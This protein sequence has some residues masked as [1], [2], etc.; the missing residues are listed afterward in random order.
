M[1]PRRHVAQ[2][3]IGALLFD[4]RIPRHEPSGQFTGQLCRAATENA[5][6]GSPDRTKIDKDA[7]APLA[8][9]S[10]FKNAT[11]PRSGR[12]AASRSSR[13]PGPSGERGVDADEPDRSSNC[14]AIRAAI[15]AVRAANI[16]FSGQA[17]G[18][19]HAERHVDFCIV[20]AAGSARPVLRAG[21]VRFQ[22]EL[23]GRQPVRHRQRHGLGLHQRNPGVVEQ[24]WRP[25]RRRRQRSLHLSAADR[26]W[27]RLRGGRRDAARGP[28]LH[29]RQRFRHG[30]RQ[31]HRRDG[32]LCPVHVHAAAVAGH[33][34]H[35]Q[36]RQ[37]QLVPD[38]RRAPGIRGAERR[39]GAAGPHA[40]EPGRFRPA[41]AVRRRG[42]RDRRRGREDPAGGG[43]EL[44][45]HEVPARAR[46]R[47]RDLLQRPQE[48]L[49]HQLPDHESLEV[50]ERRRDQRRQRDVLLLEVLAAAL[51]RELHP[52]DPQPGH[53]ARHHRR[54]L[55][56]LRRQVERR[57][58]SRRGQAG[59]DP[60]PDRLRRD[61][62]VSDQLPGL[63]LAADRR[64]RGPGP[65]AGDDGDVARRTE[66]VARRG[67]R[68]PVRRR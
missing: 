47:R 58:R 8:S 30:A 23:A 13:R 10:A 29:R 6:E 57:R 28:D 61:P 52:H 54:R 34:Q 5:S 64:R 1:P 66:G 38:C 22:P 50:P 46:R 21:G 12:S 65:R 59:H 32:E 14:A 56:L 40:A 62:H 36:G 20:P 27:Q 53:A 11:V 63:G 16:I 55:D 45:R 67:R 37:L 7:E 44:P 25:A 9:A 33:L 3:R 19:H 68:L 24:R 42:P 18:E 26:Q 43:A 51:S 60:A 41:A 2:V 39:R 48:R 17:G 15:R 49:Q 35:R 4:S 31:R